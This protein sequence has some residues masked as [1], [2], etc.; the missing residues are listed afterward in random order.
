MTSAHSASALRM[1]VLGCAEIAWRRT[2]PAMRADPD[3][4]A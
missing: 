3:V 4:R 2:L 1:A